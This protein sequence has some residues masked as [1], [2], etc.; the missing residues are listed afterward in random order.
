[1]GRRIAKQVNGS[2]VEKYL[3]SGL[4]TLLAVYDGSNNLVQ[5]FEYAGGRLP[6]AMVQAGATYYLAYDQ[7]GSLRIVSDSAG[8]VVKRI[9]YDTFGNIIDDTDTTFAL[10]FGFAGGLHDRLTGLVRFG[11]RDYDPDTGRWT[12][13]DPILF[14]GGDT[15]LY[16]YVQN[17]P[18]NFIDP[19]GL[20]DR[21]L[22]VSGVWW[23]GPALSSNRGHRPNRK[24]PGL[25]I[26]INIPDFL[27]MPPLN[28]RMN[29]I[30]NQTAWWI[31]QSGLEDAIN[32]SGSHPLHW[33]K[34]IIWWSSF[35]WMGEDYEFWEPWGHP[36]WPGNDCHH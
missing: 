31:N 21:S 16:G 17:N 32:A 29:I 8:N 14:G 27:K 30:N 13:K 23:L 4:T 6:A 2:I 36:F 34:D 1:M 25:G 10:P 12:A 15:D 18:V 33:E 20:K 11:Y 22:G 28:E 3:W 9:D 35:I 24:K 7:V 19:W 5:R 26:T